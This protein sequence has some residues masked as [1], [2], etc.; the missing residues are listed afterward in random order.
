MREKCWFIWSIASRNENLPS[1]EETPETQEG[2]GAGPPPPIGLPVFPFSALGRGGGLSPQKNI[3][4]EPRSG[5][6][7]G[8]S[9]AVGEEA[10]APGPH[11]VRLRLAGH[12]VRLRRSHQLGDQRQQ[13]GGR[14]HGTGGG[15]RRDVHG[16]PSASERAGCC[17]SQRH[18]SGPFC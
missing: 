11:A 16:R 18:S 12:D 9:Q 3:N 14:G 17:V 6:S 8:A 5:G 4:S 7:T 1:P 10:T 2:V 15:G 13:Y